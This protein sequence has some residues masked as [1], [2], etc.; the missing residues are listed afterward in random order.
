[1]S[2]KIETA[3]KMYLESAKFKLHN[4]AFL[5]LAS[6]SIPSMYVSLINVCAYRVAILSINFS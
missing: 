4:M 1:M 6:V 5:T 3:N 2:R